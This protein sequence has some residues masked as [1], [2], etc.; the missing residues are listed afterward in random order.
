MSEAPSTT[1]SA[2]AAPQKTASAAPATPSAAPPAA[3]AARAPSDDGTLRGLVDTYKHEN[4]QLASQGREALD[5]AK[6]A[7]AERD[8]LRA[9]LDKLK[10]QRETELNTGREEKLLGE[11][12][13][14]VPDDERFLAKCAYLGLVADGKL[15]RYAK[16][17]DAALKAAQEALSEAAPSLFRKRASGGGAPLQR[18]PTKVGS[19]KA[20]GLMTSV[21]DP[22]TRS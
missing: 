20:K 5:A 12:F 8:Q 16:D 7:A 18:P 22:R 10:Q 14:G 21:W 1:E 17:H 6:A 4:Q 15:E 9:E 2:P 3:P 11:L 19:R 13:K